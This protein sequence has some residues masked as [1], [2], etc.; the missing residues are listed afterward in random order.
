[1]I[2]SVGS[3]N[4][5]ES[6]RPAGIVERIGKTNYL[7]PNTG[8]KRHFTAVRLFS[9]ALF[10][11]FR[12]KPNEKFLS[13]NPERFLNDLF[14]SELQLYPTNERSRHSRELSENTAQYL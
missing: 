6:K 10:F 7:G 9:V 2:F 8:M 4:Y 3:T 1:M 14:S 13:G 5:S 12:I 11:F